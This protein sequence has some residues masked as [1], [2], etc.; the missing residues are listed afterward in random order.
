MFGFTHPQIFSFDSN[1]CYFYLVYAPTISVWAHIPTIFVLVDAPVICSWL[2]NP[3]FYFGLH[4]LHLCLGFYALVFFCL[5]LTHWFGPVYA[6]V[7][8]SRT[9]HFCPTCGCYI[10]VEQLFVPFEFVNLLSFLSFT[11]TCFHYALGTGLIYF[12]FIFF[13]CSSIFLLVHDRLIDLATSILPPVDNP[14]ETSWF[15][16]HQ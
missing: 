3:L 7:T 15:S 11:H 13:E 6:P 10:L 16:H 1:T 4:A 2:T 9:I 5:G 14:S 12:L 8:F